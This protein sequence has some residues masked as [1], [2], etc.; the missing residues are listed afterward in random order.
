MRISWPQLCG[1]IESCTR[2][3]LCAGRTR[4]VPG[5]GNPGA[6]LMLVGEGPGRQE[7]ETGRPFV[8]AAGQLLERMLAAIGLTRGEVYI[9]NVVKCRPPGNRAPTEAEAQACLP[10]LRAQFALVR[11]RVLVC[12]GA[13]PARY[14]LGPELRVTRD[15]GT[16]LARKGVSMTLTYHPAAL[17]R[18][19]EKKRDAWRDWQSIAETLRRLGEETDAQQP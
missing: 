16:W 4:A 11:P 19:G 5:E 3:P 7:D 2:C 8:G 6:R 17:L 12:L 18:D 14:L 15:H 1:Q 9:A 10:F 13:T